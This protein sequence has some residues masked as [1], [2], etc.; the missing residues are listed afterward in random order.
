MGDW[1]EDFQTYLN[2]YST[3][4]TQTLNCL[5]TL[6]HL[7]MEMTLACKLVAIDLSYVLLGVLYSE[8]VGGIP[9]HFRVSGGSPSNSELLRVFLLIT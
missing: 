1:K 9:R 3:M 7:S 5:Q 6:S 2:E 4:D 8:L